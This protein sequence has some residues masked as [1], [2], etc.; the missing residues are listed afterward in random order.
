MPKPRDPKRDEAFEIYEQSKGKIQLVEIASQLDISPGTVRGWKSKDKWDSKLNGTLQ[1]KTERSKRKRGGQPGNKNAKG[2][3]GPVG[4]LKALKH[5]AYQSIYFNMMPEDEKQLFEQLTAEAELDNE[6]KLL[7][8]KIAKLLNRNE[9]FFYN[10]FG[11][12]I[13]KDVAEEDREKG[14]LI[15]MDQLRKLIQAKAKMGFDTEK[16]EIEHEKLRLMKIRQGE[17][18]EGGA[19]DGFL[20]ALK[21]SVKEVWAD[22]C[23][24]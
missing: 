6:I 9:T 8:L 18:D 14:I 20:E 15:C 12:K 10:M 23:P 3:G 24:E 1:K 5:G 13:N 19:D 22:E 16:L 11:Q 2:H 17:D 21:G 7:R 4:N